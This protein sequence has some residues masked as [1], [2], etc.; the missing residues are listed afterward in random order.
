MAALWGQFTD[1][2]NPFGIEQV[3]VPGILGV[4]QGAQDRRVNQMLLQRKIALEDREVA[5][6]DTISSI[7]KN[8]QT[9]GQSKGGD[10]SSPTPAATPLPAPV[11]ALAAGSAPSPLTAA[12]AAPSAPLADIPGV[13]AGVGKSG[14]PLDASPPAAATPSPMGNLPPVNPASI[15]PEDQSFVQANEQGIRQL[16]GLDPEQGM[17][18]L[19]FAQGL[20]ADK[21][22]KIVDAQDAIHTAAASLQQIPYA[23]RKAALAQQA[24]DLL[25]A[26]PGLTPQMLQ[27]FDPTDQ[28][29]QMAVANAIGVKGMMEHAEKTATM[30]ETTRSHY[31]EEENA[32]NNGYL[33]AGLLPPGA[34]GAGSPIEGGGAS[35]A[36]GQRYTGG[37]TPR[38]KNGGDN[39]DAAVDSKIA[40]AAKFLGVAP[41]ADISHLSPL[42]IAQAMALSEGG[43]GSKAD[44]YNNP[45]N[46]K[47]ANG[48]F[49]QFT[50]KEEGLAAAAALVARKLSKGQ[51]TVQSMIEGMPTG[52][53][54]ST[55]ASGLRIIPGGKLDHSAEA[56]DQ[57]T[58][59]FYAQKVAAGGDLPV[60]GMG[61]EA[62]ALRRAIL[63]KSAAIQTG[64][65]ISGGDSNLV[66]ADVKSAG[67]ALTALQKTRNSLDPFLQTFDGASAQVRHLAPKA[68]AGSV[69]VF[70]RWIQAGRTGL[71][72]DPDVTKLNAAIAAVAG[73]NAKIMS[74]A[75]GG[76]VT[77]DSARHEAQAL[78][79]N[80]QTL[81]QLYVALDQMHTDTQIRL[82]AMDDRQATL[83]QTISGHG[84]TPAL[85]APV[86]VSN[87]DDYAK[88][89]SG[90]HY[91]DPQGQPRIKR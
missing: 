77:S 13:I 78:I 3:D 12:Y 72:G 17:Q 65:G 82:K 55:P 38:A 40:G 29:I 76:A 66:H 47:N 1:M 86:H 27:N 60:L 36:T 39:S 42:K 19:K 8:Y 44:R 5:K 54:S 69:P 63:A 83:R 41:S 49:K 45:A 7:W 34:P 15:T 43:A 58:V 68:V 84:T 57:A 87:A 32:R 62:A 9:P 25:A 59:D 74:G 80:A 35:G 30:A 37:W 85:S 21:R 4:Y 75:S 81:P 56:I 6:H 88:L 50:T 20:D 2:A 61:K 73:E 90:T 67:M 71:Q 31:A 18:F 23:G 53:G 51:T 10:Q 46:L 48:T 89:P 22:A 52:G 70:N 28:N 16:M 33:S 79:N 91:I 14:A 26:H 24:P 64:Q 11:A